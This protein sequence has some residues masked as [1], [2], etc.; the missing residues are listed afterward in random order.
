MSKKRLT[1]SQ[2]LE[3]ISTELVAIS[4]RLAAKKGAAAI[5]LEMPEPTAAAKAMAA[6]GRCVQCGD[7]IPSGTRDT[8]GLDAKCYQKTRREHGNNRWNE[9]IAQGLAMPPKAGGRPKKKTRLSEFVDEISDAGVASLQSLARE[10]DK[11]STAR[12]G[13]KKGQ[14]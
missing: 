6:E 14:K 3:E 12:Q 11:K 13:K 2:R 10:T 7:L 1:I 4:R 8:Y 5:S 9:L